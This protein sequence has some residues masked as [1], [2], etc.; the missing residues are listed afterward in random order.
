MRIRRHDLKGGKATVIVFDSGLRVRFRYFMWDDKWEVRVDHLH[1]EDLYGI[2]YGFGHEYDS[3]HV[4]LEAAR[5][6][7]GALFEK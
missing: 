7:L 3:R 6:G 4:A 1:N 5:E 2:G